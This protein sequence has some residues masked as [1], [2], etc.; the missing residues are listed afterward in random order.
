[1]GYAPLLENRTVFRSRDPDETHAFLVSK[2]FRFELPARAAPALDACF[3][4]VYLP[5]MYIGYVQ[6]GAPVSVR[7]VGR[8]DYWVQFPLR[9]RLEVKTGGAD[10]QCR[11]G[12]AA[13]ASPTRA[14]Y[15]QTRSDEGGA[16][17]HVCM[18]RQALLAQLTALLGE[19]PTAPIEFASE[20]DL[21]SGYGQSLA[22]YITMA[23]TDFARSDSAL[24]GIE[25]MNS[26]EEMFLTRF[27]L[28]HP[29]SYSE[30]L[31]QRGAQLS[32]RDVKRAV[33]YV[34]AHLAN[35]ISVAD[36]SRAAGVPG[37]TL[38]KHF[39]DTRGISPMRFVRNARF[40]RVREALLRAEPDESVT[41]IALGL[42][43]THMGRF[44]VEYRKRYGESP[45]ETLRKRRAEG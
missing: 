9:G 43:F 31:L 40:T 4:G 13:V 38:F 32:P 17:I 11:D 44:S 34:E 10:V 33:D 14:D 36:L 30:Q 15:Y 16:R 2:E 5:G 29:S 22:R 12:I 26:F 35:A 37:R 23:I 21:T 19:T 7:A 42:G 20:M 24:C 41:A 3:N 6:Y 39:K 28:S 25:M 1:M 45:S 27:L 8:D 18:W